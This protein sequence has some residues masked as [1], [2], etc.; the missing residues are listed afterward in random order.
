MADGR[1][2]VPAG[3]TFR[4]Q[5]Q[6]CPNFM[7]HVTPCVLSTH[8]LMKYCPCSLTSH[9]NFIHAVASSAKIRP[10]SRCQNGVRGRSLLRKLCCAYCEAVKLVP[11]PFLCCPLCNCLSPSVYCQL[12]QFYCL[13]LL[14]LLPV[15]QKGLSQLAA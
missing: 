5:L 15:K 1:R 7:C 2:Y 9:S 10:F 6:G 3:F 8:M 12:F 11:V 14:C 13:S 4:T